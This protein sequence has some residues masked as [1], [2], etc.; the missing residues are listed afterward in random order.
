LKRELPTYLSR[1]IDLFQ[2]L[3]GQNPPTTFRDYAWRSLPMDNAADD[4]LL[5]TEFTELWIPISKDTEVMQ[6]LKQ[7]FD[8]GDLAAT[9]CYTTE[10]YGAAASDFWL[11]PAYKEPVIRI[12]IF[13]CSKNAG[14]PA[15]TG[16]F[17][18]Q[19]WQLLKPFGFRLH[20]GKYLPEYDYPEW[21]QYFHRQ[22]PQLKDFL[23]LRAQM[24]PTGIFLTD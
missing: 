6:V 20:W 13:W 9:G 14:N 21:A 10:I 18:E 17:Y 11:S 8:V 19:F 24:D 15:I 4:I 23:A 1:V 5:G 16:G 7:H 22:L 2:P 3:T 12:D